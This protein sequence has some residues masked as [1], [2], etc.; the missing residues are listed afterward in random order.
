[1]ERG[2][3]SNWFPQTPRSYALNK[4]TTNQTT[5]TENKEEK[6]SKRKV[7]AHNRYR[8]TNSLYFMF[9]RMKYER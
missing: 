8:S 4:T 1:M 5:T 9:N 3:M 6:Y 2:Q 7:Q